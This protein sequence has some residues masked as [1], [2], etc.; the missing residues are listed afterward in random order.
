[1]NFLILC[2]ALAVDG[3]PSL[4]ASTTVPST[5]TGTAH[6][7]TS[8]NFEVIGASATVEATQVAALCEQWRAKLQSYWL[9]EPTPHWNP[10]CKVI[11]HS[12]RSSYLSA[13][14]RGGEQT[15]G[16]SWIEFKAEQVSRRQIDLLGVDDLGLTALPHEMTHV[17][18]ADLFKG[19]QPPRWADEGAAMLADTHEKQQLH[20]RDLEASVARRIGFR[21]GELFAAEHYPQPHRVPGFYGQSVSVTAFLARRDDPAKFVTF[22]RLALDHGHDRALRDV[23]GLDGTA[24]LEQEWLAHRYG[25]RGYHG[26]RLTLDRRV[27]KTGVTE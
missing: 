14:G 1:M 26:L 10:R 2:L 13:V 6:H 4:T 11:L 19:R 17:I 20:Q 3:T 24:E 22:I 7:A 5:I 16:S 21:V 18:F 12:T 23:Y 15:R 27:S 9:Q 8:A 25:G